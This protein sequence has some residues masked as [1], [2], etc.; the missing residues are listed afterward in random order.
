MKNISG[1]C[2]LV[3]GGASAVGS[4]VI[5]ELVK[6][7][8]SVLAVDST[9][10]RIEEAIAKLG[11]ENPDEIFTHALEG[12]DLVSWWDLG[13]LIAAYFHTLNLFVHVAEPT[14]S[15]PARTLGLDALREAEK[16]SSDSFLTAVARLEKY[17]VAASEEDE[18]G[19]NVVAVQ[20]FA[21]DDAEDEAPGSLCHAKSLTL[22][23]ALTREY[24]EADL[25]IRVHAVRAHET[26]AS[27]SALAIADVVGL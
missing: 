10:E 11:L 18:V 15:V 14:P 23:D 5:R 9:E 16:T 17:L 1:V 22:A 20:L 25:N 7:G 3:S 24:A 26:D 27:D 12:G 2:A 19:A 8:A 13:N 21:G 6:R 4:E